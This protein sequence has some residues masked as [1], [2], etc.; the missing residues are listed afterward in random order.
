MPRHYLDEAPYAKRISSGILGRLELPFAQ[1]LIPVRGTPNQT[2]FPHGSPL[3]ATLAE[4]RDRK[5]TESWTIPPFI[6][7]RL[8]FD[9][10][11]G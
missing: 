10:L 3:H 1:G 2:E 8:E 9:P 4:Y 6:L 7:F 5:A 11:S